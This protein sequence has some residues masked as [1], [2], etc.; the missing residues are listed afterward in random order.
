MIKH[1]LDTIFICRLTEASKEV[2]N[3][4]IYYIKEGKV[5]PVHLMENH[6]VAVF[7]FPLVSMLLGN[8]YFWFGRFANNLLSEA[9]PNCQAP[10]RPRNS[11]NSPRFSSQ[12][13]SA[14]ENWREI[15][16]L[17]FG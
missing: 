1:P 14:S 5:S 15:R 12:L 6:S 7:D 16:V 13:N 9:V 11:E 3:S 17:S 10:S 8:T 2:Q 4:D